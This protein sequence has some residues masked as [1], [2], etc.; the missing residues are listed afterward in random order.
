M[1]HYER[2]QTF[3]ETN[4]AKQNTNPE[5]NTKRSSESL[6]EKSKCSARKAPQKKL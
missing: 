5:N 1:K 6:P 3:L 2:N 4:L